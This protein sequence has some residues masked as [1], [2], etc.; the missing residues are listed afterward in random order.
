MRWRS[1][2][3]LAISVLLL[4]GCSRMGGFQSMLDTAGPAAKALSHIFWVMF[5][6]SAVVYV[7]VIGSL[8]GAIFRPQPVVVDESAEGDRRRGMV[9]VVA[10]GLTVV[11]LFVLLAVSIA[12]GK[13]VSGIQSKNAISIDVVGHQWWWEVRYND[14]VASQI[15]TT[16][17]EIH[18]PVGQPVVINTKS[19]DVIHSFWPPNI[20]GKRDNIPGYTN[21]FWIEADREGTYRGQCAEFCGHQHAHM[22]FFIVVEPMAK[23]QAWMAQQ[24]LPAAQPSDADQKRGQSVFLRSPCTMC[25]TIRGTG[26]G[27]TVGPDLTHLASRQM[28]GAGTLPNT[29]GNLA[30]WILDSQGIKPG[31]KMP[32][33]PLRPEDLQA[34]LAYL[35]SLK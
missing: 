25:H 16:A 35:E 13:R 19:N 2:I 34:L 4:G 22:S 26:S 33:N 15:V 6:V 20:H 29:P 28:I 11:T 21:A 27:A 24:R 8:L 32:P 17:N 5:W 18:I 14:P 31:N 1:T 3:P 23:F 12:T 10:V 9:V 30:G 7:L